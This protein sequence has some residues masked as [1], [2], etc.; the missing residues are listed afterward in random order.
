MAWGGTDLIDPLRSPT[1]G[2]AGKSIT[3][4]EARFVTNLTVSYDECRP[5]RPHPLKGH[6][7]RTWETS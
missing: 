1:A 3:V 2:D 7:H 5:I 6:R 4:I